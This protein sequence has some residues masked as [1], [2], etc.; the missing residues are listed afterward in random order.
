MKLRYLLLF[1]LLSLGCQKKEPTIIVLD[2]WWNADYAKGVCQTSGRCVVDPTYEVRGFESEVASHIAS[3]S[4]CQ[5]VQFVRF[6]NPNDANPVAS[7]AMNGPHW[8]LTL[9]YNPGEPRQ[10]WS[11]H[12]SGDKKRYPEFGF[13]ASTSGEGNPKE[14]AHTICS[15]ATG[16]G[17]SLEN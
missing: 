2:G 11:M 7:K 6:N 16:K 1:V 5:G 17:G 3:D 10:W 4:T 13:G 14:I 9:S 15:I 12:R 8:F